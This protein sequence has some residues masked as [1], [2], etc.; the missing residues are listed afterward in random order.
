MPR[1]NVH[2]L[3]LSLQQVQKQETLQQALLVPWRQLDAT[4]AEYVRWHSFVLWVRTVSESA[5]E[6]PSLLRSELRERCP[7]FLDA[8]GADQQRPLWK[9]LEDWIETQSFGN[10][11]AAGWFGAVVYYAYKDLRVEQGW[12]LWERMKVAWR[13]KSPS[14]WP[15]FEE[16]NAQV[17]STHALLRQGTE[18]AWAVAA[19]ANVD[20][21]RLRTAIADVL[22]RRA[23]A[24]WV[25]CVSKPQQPLDEA[26][27]TELQ[28]RCP[29]FTAILPTESRWRAP[30][31]SRLIRAGESDWRS[32]SRREGWYSALRYC[33][34]HHPRYQRFVHYRQ[35]CHDEWLTVRPISFP[36]F[37]AWLAYAD[38]YCVARTP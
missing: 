7:G 33:V 24:L 25:D 1:E 21:E 37:P 34:A 38:A 36:S 29:S 2:N 15:T 31:L 4:I 9:S 16:W 5:G 13:Q 6:L 20:Q 27:W 8:Y 28:H 26:V 12:S 23:L 32:V 30:L 3:V 17:A 14:R 35:R 22:D 10:V 18:K 19:L 11:R